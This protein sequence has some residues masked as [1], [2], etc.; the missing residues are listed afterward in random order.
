MFSFLFFCFPH[1]LYK[2]TKPALCF[3]ISISVFREFTFVSFGNFKMYPNNRTWACSLLSCVLVLLFV[4]GMSRILSFFSG[5]KKMLK[6]V[7]KNSLS[8]FP[9][10]SMY[11]LFF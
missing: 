8:S 1:D 9:Y 6:A 11:L 7:T 2:A 3:V 4:V 10:K 5:K